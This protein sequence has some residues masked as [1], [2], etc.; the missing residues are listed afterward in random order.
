MN[1]QHLNAIYAD[2]QT[3]YVVLLYHKISFFIDFMNIEYLTRING[4]LCLRNIA[5]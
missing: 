5:L 1:N 3:V 4:I 2:K